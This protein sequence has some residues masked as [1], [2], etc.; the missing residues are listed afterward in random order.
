[1]KLLYIAT[2]QSVPGKTGGSVHVEEVARGLAARGHEVH[3][4]ALAGE[5]NEGAVRPYE[6][7]R[8]RLP[9]GHRALRFTT[10]GQI[11]DLLDRLSV[12]AVM[13]RYYNFAGEGI[14]AAHRRGVPSLLEVNSPLRD[15]PGSLKSALDALLVVRPMK[16]LRNE[17]A[18]KADA[19][20]TPLLS[21]VPDDVPRE[22]VHRVSWGANVDLFRPGV[23]AKPLDIP[24][25]RRVVVFSGS[26]RPWHGADIL[27]RAAAL[28]VARDPEA[29]FLF[30]GGGPSFEK[31]KRLVRELGLERSTLLTGAVPYEEMPSYLKRARLGVAPYQPS[32]LGQMKLGFYWSPLKIFEYMAMALPV[33]TL[34]TPPLAEIVRPGEEGLLVPEGNVE[35][36]ATAIEGLL[37]DPVRAQTMGEA[38]RDRVV[39]RFSWQKHC[40]QLE[41]ILEGLVGKP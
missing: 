8:S 13:E 10:A 11:G 34:E 7:H 23:E 3:V 20:V 35:A 4:V 30:L 21:I 22:K 16:R 29:F 12:D 1:V 37:S 25:H 6:L 26:F 41:R 31:T 14:R 5:R 2:D 17:I 18:R 19:L 15:H 27:A 9:F 36:L 24:P 33:V 40:E 38:A 28:V 32:A 39:A